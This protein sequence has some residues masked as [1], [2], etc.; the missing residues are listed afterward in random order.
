MTGAARERKAIA[1][2]LAELL[3]VI[4]VMALLATIGLPAL[5]GF[6]KGN[7]MNAATRQMLDDL[8]LARM[9]AINSRTTV[10][11]VFV[12]TNIHTYFNARAPA[13]TNSANAEDR[14]LWRQL[15]NAVNGAY[16]SYALVSKR[17]VGDQ[18]GRE[19]PQ[20]LT[21]WKRLP[22]GVVVPDYKFLR[23]NK[24]AGT[25]AEYFEGFAYRT[26]MA[27]PGGLPFPLAESFDLAAP[28]LALR[29]PVIAFNPQGQLASGQD[30]ML[31][32]AD[33]SVFYTWLPNGGA[34]KPDVLVKPQKNYTNNFIRINWLTGRAMLEKKEM[35]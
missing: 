27:Q 20:Y 22:E 1:F 30:E 33:G 3:V 31:P 15:S 29:L 14:R 34:G 2:T 4:A 7:A 9:R 35:R 17:M 5:K 12:P 18:P 32:L 28:A 21:E 6:G 8:S 19:H 26:N 23:T 16:T 25:G 10:Y 24:L 11:V 13:L